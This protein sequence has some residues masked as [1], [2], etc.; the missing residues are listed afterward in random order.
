MGGL[1][2]LEKFEDKAFVITGGAGGVGGVIAEQLLHCG[3]KV[4]LVG[5]TQQKLLRLQK[6]LAK[7]S[8]AVAVFEQD[9]TG[10]HA[11]EAIV[12]K[13]YQCFGR[14]DGV[15]CAAGSYISKPLLDLTDAD[16]TQALNVNLTAPFTLGQAFA[17]TWMRKKTTGCLIYIGSVHAVVADPLSVP[18]SASKAGLLGLTRAMAEACRASGIRVNAISPGAI[19]PDSGKTHSALQHARVTQKDVAQLVL[20]LVS[21]AAAAVTGATVDLFGQSRPF[22]AQQSHESLATQTLLGC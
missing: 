9:V 2:L 4:L 3:A 20:Y 14:C 13:I 22:L 21:D 7:Y 10:A 1:T 6:V 5:R 18:Q 16:W 17:R 11:A 12:K 19:E 15:I 8:S